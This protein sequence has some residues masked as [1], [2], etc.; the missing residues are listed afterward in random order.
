MVVMDRGT[1]TV[2]WYDGTTSAEM[3]EH[4]FGCVLRRLNQSSSRGGGGKFKLEDVRLLDENVEPHEGKF[5]FYT[6]ISLVSFFFPVL[7]H[8]FVLY[9]YFN[10]LNRSGSMSISSRWVTIHATISNR[11][12]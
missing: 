1:I 5:L 9:I 12:R 8:F 6:I 10:P 3:Q 7:T 2:S 11:R 4:V